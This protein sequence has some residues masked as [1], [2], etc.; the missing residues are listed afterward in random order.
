M[1]NYNEGLTKLSINLTIRFFRTLN[2]LPLRSAF[3]R[4]RV[5]SNIQP[6]RG[7]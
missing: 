2:L 6:R 1:H 7:Q 4:S 3:R 5:G